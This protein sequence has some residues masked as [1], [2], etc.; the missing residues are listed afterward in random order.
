MPSYA[1]EL[2]RSQR[3]AV[4]AACLLAAGILVAFSALDRAL[5]PRDFL[6]LLAI[7]GA[8]ALLLLA[9]ARWARTGRPLLVLSCAV[10]LTAGTIEAALLLT[11]AA[12]SPYQF[13]MMLVQAG[14]ALLVPLG[15][16]EAALLNLEVLGIA[17]LPLALRAAP[18]HPLDAVAASY[19]GCMAVVSV[20]GAFVQDRLRRKEHQARGEF[21]RH[22]G[23]LNLGTLAGG[24]AHELA[25]PLNALGLQVEMLASDPASVEKRVPRLLSSVGRMRDILEAMRNG[26]R[27]NGGER[28]SVDL[29]H[30]MDLAFTLMESRLR[31]RVSLVRAYAQIPK[32]F[33]QPTLLG[34]VLVNLLSNA[35]D[36]VAGRPHPRIALRLRQEG[37]FA[38]VEVED[39]G[40]G[41]PEELHE[42][43]FLPF[44][45]TKGDSGNGLGLWISSEIAR[46][47]GGSLSVES[48][49]FG[50]ALFRLTLPIDPRETLREPAP[51]AAAHA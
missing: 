19:L 16:A 5:V 6:P 29:A 36:A 30:E 7:R 23:L 13:S 8:A 20:G 43:I 14:L 44:F 35:A 48:G 10:A 47:H 1:E 38:V 3:G 51:Q 50:G 22:F 12:G 33:C 28:R 17:L 31:N 39:N 4:R 18:V 11:G 42:Q 40:P 15:L 32:V 2:G 37:A 24:L 25:N 45:S 27:V 49:S 21:A 41:V 26:A 9:C 46:I 34:Q